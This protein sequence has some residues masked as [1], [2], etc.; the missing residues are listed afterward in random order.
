GAIEVAVLFENAQGRRL[1]D[2][3]QF[4]SATPDIAGPALRELE[5][6]FD[7]AGPLL[8]ALLRFDPGALCAQVMRRVM[9]WAQECGG[10]G[11]V[12][13]DRDLGERANFL[14]RIQ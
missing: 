3:R 5:L 2:A 9:F 11:A 12:L 10:A 14:T 6:A 7:S 13:S 1:R 4:V 8:L